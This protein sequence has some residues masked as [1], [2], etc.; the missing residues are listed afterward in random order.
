MKK[1]LFSFFIALYVVFLLIGTI[2]FA[3]EIYNE[4]LH[5]TVPISLESWS[6]DKEDFPSDI[7]GDI[8]ELGTSPAPIFGILLIQTQMILKQL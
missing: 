5:Q 3:F 1:K 2:S 6:G 4:V 7:D 8:V